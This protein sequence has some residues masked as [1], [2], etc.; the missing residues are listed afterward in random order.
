MN[1]DYDGMT[2]QTAPPLAELLR[3]AR[4][5]R[6]HPAVLQ[7]ANV[8]QRSPWVHEDARS[9]AQAHQLRG[10]LALADFGP[11]FRK[12]NTE[13]MRVLLAR[14]DRCHKDTRL[15]TLYEL[16]YY[17]AYGWNHTD[18]VVALGSL[19][20]RQGRVR[21]PML[22]AGQGECGLSLRTIDRPFVGGQHRILV[23]TPR[24]S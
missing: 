11:G 20:I 17:A 10:E 1:T 8:Y 2:T 7:T 18:I 12:Y 5:T 23:V 13:I 6:R 14:A 9:D 15:A 22:W 19:H 21:V 4:L 3:G 16:V 24:S